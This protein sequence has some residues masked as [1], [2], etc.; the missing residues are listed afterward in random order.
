MR[1]LT[2]DSLAVLR[3]ALAALFTPQ[4]LL[5]GIMLDLRLD[6]RTLATTWMQQPFST[7]DMTL[8]QQQ[9]CEH[10]AILLTLIGTPNFPTKEP[11]LTP[12]RWREQK[13]QLD[14]TIHELREELR[15]LKGVD[16]RL[17]SVAQQLKKCQAK[18]SDDQRKIDQLENE[19]RQKNSALDL[20]QEK[21]ARETAHRDQR[22]KAAVDLA[23]ATEFHGWL[24]HAKTVEADT[25]EAYSCV[26]P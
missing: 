9:V 15:R 4:S 17:S 25:Q 10:F 18:E 2:P 7:P 12:E 6:V 24:A 11:V 26:L 22:V 21:L 14:L 20:V 1:Q 13:N 19:L 23:L 3:H 5:V 8:A 16:D